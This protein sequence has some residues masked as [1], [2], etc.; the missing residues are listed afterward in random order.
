[1]KVCWLQV[2]GDNLLSLI[3][4][5]SYRNI[6]LHLVKHIAKQV[7]NPSL[8]PS[9]LELKGGV[10]VCNFPPTIVCS[11]KDI[12]SG[13]QGCNVQVLIGLDYIHR[14]L[15]II[16]TDLKP[17]NVMLSCIVR[18]KKLPASEASRLHNATSNGRSA[19]TDE[20]T[21]DAAEGQSLVISCP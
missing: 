19:P 4:A 20:H 8:N 21:R 9:A 3:K 17:E 12:G 10:C 7:S 2:L 15:S 5:Y 14:K 18:E 16:H 6:P 11:S 13:V 1:M